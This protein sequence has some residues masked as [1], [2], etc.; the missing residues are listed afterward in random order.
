AARWGWMLG[1]LWAV[2][3]C[4]LL[5]GAV[6]VAALAPSAEQGAILMAVFSLP[7]A[8]VIALAPR[9][10]GR[11]GL[12]SAP[13]TANAGGVAPVLWHRPN[14]DAMA[15]E[16]V[17]SALRVSEASVNTRKE[18]SRWPVAADARLALRLAGLSLTLGC[19]WALW[20]RLWAQWQAW[21]A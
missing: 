6:G 13:A 2:L 14:G 18:G 1:G 10:L 9:G 3:P 19:G 16:S 12:V 11:L 5:Y 15:A 4:G 17:G 21:C 20:H 8:V 7:G